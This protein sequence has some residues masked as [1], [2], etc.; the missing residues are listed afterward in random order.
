[1]KQWERGCGKLASAAKPAGRKRFRSSFDYY[2][3]EVLES[4]SLR[5]RHEQEECGGRLRASADEGSIHA[6]S[7][8]AGQDPL[9]GLRSKAGAFDL[10]EQEKIWSSEKGSMVDALE[11]LYEEG[12]G[13]LRKAAGRSTH[14][15]IRGWPNGVTRRV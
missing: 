11:L 12:R 10:E 1:M 2:R 4:R 3:L 5:F 9:T 8:E 7:V 15:E 6:G 14:P 13:K